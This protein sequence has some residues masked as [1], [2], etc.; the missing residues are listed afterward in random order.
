MLEPRELGDLGLSYIRERLACGG[1]LSRLLLEGLDLISGHAWTYL[2]PSVTDAQMARFA[3]AGITRLATGTAP[4]AFEHSAGHWEAVH[5]VATPL[6]TA[7]VANFLA[8]DKRRVAVWNDPLASADDR[9]VRD[10][11]EEPLLFLGQE[12]YYALSH[13]T[14]SPAAIAAGIGAMC[15]WWGSPAVLAELPN[16]TLRPFVSQRAPLAIQDLQALVDNCRML[17][18]LAY[19]GEGCVLWSPAGA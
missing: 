18:F 9:W 12:V 2:P 4:A 5:N 19:D 17:F 3:E 16:E 6:L 13:A 11:P 7:Q 1:V 14:R 8:Q 15:A 10:H